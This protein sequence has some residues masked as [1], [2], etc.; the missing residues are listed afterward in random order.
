MNFVFMG[1]NHYSFLFSSFIFFTSTKWNVV[2]MH[3]ALVDGG[4]SSSLI[5]QMVCIPHQ[6]L[7]STFVAD[8][9]NASYRY[10]AAKSSGGLSVF[11]ATNSLQHGF[12]L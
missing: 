6:F 3:F 10:L 2:F 12:M 8:I 9:N 1:I 5:S 11:L 4:A 7:E